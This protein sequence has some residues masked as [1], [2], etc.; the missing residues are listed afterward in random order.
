MRT[1]PDIGLMI[2]T[3]SK[4]AADLLQ[5][6]RFW[7]CISDTLEHL[8]TSLLYSVARKILLILDFIMESIN[9]NIDNIVDEKNPFFGYVNS[10]ERALELVKD[11]ENA[12]TTKFTVYTKTKNF[13]RAGEFTAAVLRANI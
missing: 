6:A 8:V 11:Y 9:L 2:A 7:L 5:L 13:G 4:P 3:C 1:H 12:T 10:L